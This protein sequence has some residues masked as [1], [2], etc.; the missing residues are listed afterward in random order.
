MKFKSGL[1]VCC[2]AILGGI[3]GASLVLSEV[4][5]QVSH[6]CVADAKTLTA[7]S[8]N[9]MDGNG[10]VRCRLTAEGGDPICFFYGAGGETRLSIGLLGPD[11]N[12][13][14]FIALSDK[15]GHERL[16]IGLGENKEKKLGSYLRLRDEEGRARLL[17]SLQEGFGPSYSLL[18]DSGAMRGALVQF[19]GKDQNAG[20][21]LAKPATSETAQF[22]ISELGPAINLTSGKTSLMEGVNPKLG[23]KLYLSNSEGD[24]RMRL[25]V[26]PSGETSIWRYGKGIY[27]WVDKQVERDLKKQAELMPKVEGVD[28]YGYPKLKGH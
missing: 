15:N 16:G 7:N 14:P 10:H 26:E 2:A 23:T 5:A 6:E 18:D 1:S 8:I 12:N 21:L 4:K 25:S 3:A 20:L 9:L 27:G 19:D 11:E 17:A 24:T 28:L 13:S 22:L